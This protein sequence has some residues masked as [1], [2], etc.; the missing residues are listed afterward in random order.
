VVKGG[1]RNGSRTHA[2]ADVTFADVKKRVI[3]SSKT[4]ALTA[5]FLVLIAGGLFLY[6]M[7]LAPVMDRGSP[8]AQ[9]ERQE[10]KG[11]IEPR[12]SGQL[13]PNARTDTPSGAPGTTTGAGTRE[14][15]APVGQAAPQSC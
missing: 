4:L 12:P 5:F 11:R 8:A 10:S 7:S 15:N 1:F 14:G 9:A 3:M 6:G 2:F 13:P